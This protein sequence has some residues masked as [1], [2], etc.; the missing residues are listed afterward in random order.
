MPAD[1]AKKKQEL[2]VNLIIRTYRW[3]ESCW[4]VAG[5]NRLG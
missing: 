5:F 1:V 4:N 2:P 3:Q